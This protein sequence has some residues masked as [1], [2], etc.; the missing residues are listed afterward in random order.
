[1]LVALL[2]GCTGQTAARPSASPVARPTT[3]PVALATGGIVEYTIPSYPGACDTCGQRV[4]PLAPGPDGNIWFVAG[5][6]QV[7]GRITPAGKVSYFTM[8]VSL[9]GGAQ[10]ITAGPDHN[11][12]V[13]GRG[14]KPGEP[15]W[16]LRVSVNGDIAK[17]PTP[18]V[19]AGTESITAGPD[20]NVWFT[21]FWIS[22]VARITSSGVVTE[23]ALPNP[24]AGPRG[25]TAGPDGN[26]WFAE[27]DRSRP[28]I[29]RISPQGVETDFQVGQ[30]TTDA[31]P[32][33]IIAGPDGNLWI[34][35]RTNEGL[36]HISLQG[37]FVGVPLPQGSKPSKAIAGP[38]DNVWF[39]DPGSN[40]IARVSVAGVIREFPLPRRNSLPF[41]LALGGDGR[42]W[43][44]EGGRIASIGVKV[45]EAAFSDRTLIYAGTSSRTIT[46]TNT[47]DAAL[48]IGAVKLA[49][50]DRT[51]FAVGAETCSGK[52]LNPGARCEISVSH[53]AGGPAD[54]V[55]SALL[56]VADNGTGTPQRVSLVAHLRSCK[57]P[58][59]DPVPNMPP[60]GSMLDTTT[61]RGLYEPRGGFTYVAGGTGVSTKT[62]PV[63]SGV[64]AGYYDWSAGRW[65]PVT[66][67]GVVSPDGSSYAY[68]LFPFDSASA[69][70]LHLVDVVSGREHVLPLGAGFWSVVAFTER[71][72][73]LHQA[74]EGIGP[75]LWL[76]DPDSG[77]MRRVLDSV[78][79]DLV[80]GSTAWF[81]DRN[82]AD[83]LPQ[84]G[85]GGGSNEVGG[86]DLATGATRTWL[87]VPGSQMYVVGAYNGAPVV[88][89]ADQVRLRYFFV[90]SP[91]QPMPLDLPFTAEDSPILSGFVSDPQGLWIGSDDGVYLWTARTGG[92][93]VS[94][95]ASIPAGTCA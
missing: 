84:W 54:V 55:Q 16:V 26:L 34:T 9:A 12:W 15:D 59:V 5:G 19:D 30:G 13:L 41:G 93:L 57:L 94:T 45:P 43:F 70:D 92:I 74:Y 63:L 25:I 48:T 51:A 24:N 2:V 47:G 14:D 88:R 75:G 72:I 18:S 6:S 39:T 46:V 38:D 95:E 21:E 62:E 10:T 90:V 33:D 8:P 29:G 20:G 78:V 32:Y 71:G 7:V 22:R 27:S 87:Y 86:R 28:A 4:G 83:T 91:N 52:S 23:F 64:G 67:A 80:Q 17:F 36:G 69:R 11:M 76:V 44:G 66:D 58:I 61:G 82:A 53:A 1:V 37:R 73:Y 40:A 35:R 42:I 68:I 85:M 81:G 65:L 3:R 77:S 49:G 56:E 31:P 50:A 89:V 79:V 60:Q